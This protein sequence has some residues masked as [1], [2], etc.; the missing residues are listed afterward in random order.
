MLGMK[1]PIFTRALMICASVKPVVAMACSFILFSANAEQGDF[2]GS[3]ARDVSPDLRLAKKVK[4]P[5]V[6]L[7]AA[8]NPKEFVFY[9]ID[10]DSDGKEDFIIESKVKEKTCFV[11][12]EF[13]T[14]SCEDFSIALRGSGFKYMLF[15][16]LDDTPMLEIFDL[17]GD[18][19]Y[20]DYAIKRF[21]KKSWKLEKIVYLNPLID[22]NT[23]ERKGL[24]W[25]YPWDITAFETKKTDKGIQV[26]ATFDH[27]FAEDLFDDRIELRQ[28]PAIVLQGVPTQ[29]GPKGG[30]EKVRSKLKWMTLKEIEAATLKRF[31]KK[32]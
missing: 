24:Y 4:T 22:S 3:S 26:L 14:R 32:K 9:A 29:G 18:E 27:D 11:N 23:A 7:T 17:D 28:G 19:D 12:S 31:E 5:P 21:N 15:A 20:S 16:Q 30:F 13:K 25:G 6:K 2:W 8:Y 10:L 1:I